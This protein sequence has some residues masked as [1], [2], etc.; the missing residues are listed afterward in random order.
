[1]DNPINTGETPT[2]TVLVQGAGVVPFD[3]AVNRV[4]FRA[5]DGGGVTR[6]STGVA[7]RTVP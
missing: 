3:P 2:Y 1:M 4:S 5:K 6:G 7:T